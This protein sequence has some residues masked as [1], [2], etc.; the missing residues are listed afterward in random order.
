MAVGGE[1]AELAKGFIS[2][3]VRWQGSQ[4]QIRRDLQGIQ[5]EAAIVGAK[6]GKALGAGVAGGV[7]AGV[8]E[9]KAHINQMATWA[10]LEIQKNVKGGLTQ[11]FMS[12]ESE[13]KL[14]GAVIGK[15][16]SDAITGPIVMGRNIAMKGLSEV[17]SFAGKIGGH[18]KSTL[19]GPLAQMG[20]AAGVLGTAFIQRH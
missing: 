16:L 20:V 9:A 14:R 11:G 12:G 2:L 10:C 15:H 18:I 8:Q 3:S 13:A 5:S 6:S 17:E 7:G 1:G 4:N 19:T